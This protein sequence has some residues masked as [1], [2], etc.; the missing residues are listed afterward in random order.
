MGGTVLGAGADTAAAA[1]QTCGVRLTGMVVFSAA[2]RRSAV[3]TPG[4]HTTYCFFVVACSSH[5]HLP[6]GCGGR[7]VRSPVAYRR[8]PSSLL[9]HW[10][11]G[12]AH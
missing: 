3:A 9:A 7:A 10:V 6:V 8:A 12:L 5:C 1:A 4:E 2:K 11:G